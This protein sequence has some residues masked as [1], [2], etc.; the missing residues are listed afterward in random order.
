MTESLERQLET[1]RGYS[2]LLEG[3][4]W[5]KKY[6]P[7]LFLDRTGVIR[8]VSPA[9][10]GLKYRAED[11][12]GN[13]YR[14]FLSADL[15]EEALRALHYKM[16]VARTH[17]TPEKFA[18]RFTQELDE[19]RTE[20][21]IEGKVRKVDA[22][23]RAYEHEQTTEQKE[24]VSEARIM[25]GDGTCVTVPDV[26]W[27]KKFKGARGWTYAGAVVQLLVKES[28][29]SL[30]YKFKRSV[31]S[32]W[33]EL[34]PLQGLETYNVKTENVIGIDDLTDPTDAA[35][36][37]AKLTSGPVP[38]NPLV[39]DC[40]RLR[41]LSEDSARKCKG[42]IIAARYIAQAGKLIVGNARKQV[43]ELL[44]TQFNEAMAAENSPV[45]PATLRF[46]RLKYPE[47]KRAT[48]SGPEPFEILRGAAL[49]QHVA[50]G[51]NEIESRYA[52][53]VPKPGV[54]P[55]QANP[56]GKGLDVPAAGQ[57]AQQQP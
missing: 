49:E 2:S 35:H 48:T 54:S 47:V 23:I 56:E 55:V 53:N 11:L 34:E 44:I 22:L 41:D 9:I 24:L 20:L 29:V 42:I 10:A 4:L 26:L 14:K 15:F 46:Y 31:V 5:E 28:D 7:L 3:A 57:G 8:N 13:E 36:Y 17:P 19:A 37:A 39:F 40:S 16:D 38:T 18:P 1:E 45:K 32:L 21:S 6:G 33:K 51:I 52:N 27:L 25:L 30:W 43:R 12:V 50:D